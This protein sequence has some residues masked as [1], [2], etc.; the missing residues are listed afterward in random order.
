MYWLADLILIVHFAFV[1][2]VVGG[3][4]AIWIGAAAGW[5]WV[6]NF[7]FR[8]AHLAAICFV[9]AEALIGTVCPLTEWED[10]LRGRGTDTSFIA[11]WLHRILFYS[12]PEWVFTAA[13]VL[14]ALVVA[15]TFWLAPPR[16]RGK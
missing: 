16:Q 15:L 8:I 7:W 6:R 5:R 4:P 9:A 11:R 3:L 13:Y 2:F 14:F 10:A 1:L 12:F